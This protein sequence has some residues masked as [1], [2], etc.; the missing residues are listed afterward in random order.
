MSSPAPVPAVVTIDSVSVL[1]AVGVAEVLPPTRFTTYVRDPVIS[2]G[3][4]PYEINFGDKKIVFFLKYLSS[5]PK[6]MKHIASCRVCQHHFKRLY[7]MSDTRGPIFSVLENT[8]DEY[9]DPVD[10]G[11]GV[12]K[13]AYEVIREFGKYSTQACE[14]RI[15]SIY[16]LCEEDILTH[17]NVDSNTSKHIDPDFAGPRTSPELKQRDLEHLFKNYLFDSGDFRTGYVSR[18]IKKLIETEP[19]HILDYIIEALIEFEKREPAPIVLGASL[20]ILTCRRAITFCR[21]IL[22]RFN[23]VSKYPSET[24]LI[25][26]Y[27]EVLTWKDPLMKE[28]GGYF[29]C[30][31]KSIKPFLDLYDRPPYMIKRAVFD[32]IRAKHISTVEPSVTTITNKSRHLGNSANFTI[33]VMTDGQLPHEIVKFTG[34]GAALSPEAMAE[35][36]EIKTRNGTD[37]ANIF[38]VQEFLKKYHGSSVKIRIPLCISYL[39]LTTLEQEYICEY[40]KHF[41]CWYKCGALEANRFMDVGGIIPSSFYERGD[42][43]WYVPDLKM[44]DVSVKTSSC[45]LWQLKPE[46]RATCKEYGFTSDGTL[47]PEIRS[48]DKQHV[49]G[50]FTGLSNL[51]TSELYEPVTFLINGVRITCTYWDK[52]YAKNK[53]K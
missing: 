33:K 45:H 28:C 49:T 19:Y 51:D 14:Q 39:S 26:F 42:I 30:H 4:H 21:E 20:S 43:F 13:P 22:T 36:H 25:L 17:K 2:R 5:L 15:I 10:S 8:S 44:P 16:I 11:R 23:A 18:F 52:S 1:D 12:I 50:V 31:I 6:G 27:I 48:P 9:S 35:L 34:D 53:G 40:I 24:E 46:Y 3:L 47:R 29:N 32:M 37:G 7:N 38:D 41:R